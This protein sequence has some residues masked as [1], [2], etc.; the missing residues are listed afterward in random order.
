M[1]SPNLAAT[2][3]A[4]E[5]RSTSG[6]RPG[7]HLTIDGSGAFSSPAKGG[8]T[9]AFVF[10]DHDSSYRSARVTADKNCNTLVNE[11]KQW[12][13]HTGRMPETMWL[14]SIRT[15]N[16]FMCTPLVEFCLEKG[17][18]LTACAP[19]THEQ[20]AI[21]ETTVKMIKRVVRRNE[22]MARTGAKLRALCWKYTAH[23]LN[24]TQT[25]TDPSGH[26]RSQALQWP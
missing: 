19:H 21:A 4:T 25:S 15:D 6:M 18:N 24:R 5:M 23:Q 3:Q 7:S 9:Q 13:A 8:F 14:R 26:M 11:V 20:N 10:T 16:E 17:I 2:H 1:E 22:C 12:I